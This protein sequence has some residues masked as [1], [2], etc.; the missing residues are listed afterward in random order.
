MEVAEL[1]VLVGAAL[2]ESGRTL[3]TAES[4]TGGA[5]AASLTAIAG[6]SDYFPGG[7]VSYSNAVKERLL[8]VPKAIL[9]SVGPVSPECAEAMAKGARVRIDTDFGLSTTGI[10]GPG[11]AEEGK[12]VGLVYIA[13]A[14]PGGVTHERHQYRGRRAEVID[15]ATKAALRYALAVISA[16]HRVRV[17][18]TTDPIDGHGK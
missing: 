2:R 17:H 16:P 10:A 4:C 12:E 14:G 11:G 1:A 13:I 15:A 7:I 3:A 9:D 6:S 18:N 5:V 8:G